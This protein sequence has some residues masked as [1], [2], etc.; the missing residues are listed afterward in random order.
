MEKTS[1]LLNAA[2]KI[3]R[4]RELR[5]YSQEYLASKLHITQNTYSK[6]E[7]GETALSIEKLTD[8]CNALEI[9]ITTL[10]NFDDKQIFNYCTQ[11]GN[12]GEQSIFHY[13]NTLETVQKLYERLL[14]V[15]EDKIIR[16]K[17]E[18]NKIK[19]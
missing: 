13:N 8:I 5:G 15:K 6:I 16:L 9:D 14:L 12:F 19:E 10:F 17:N 18:L 3:R 11:T 7:R 2:T 4:I 1:S